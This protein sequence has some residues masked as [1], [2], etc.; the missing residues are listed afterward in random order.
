MK[1]LLNVLFNRKAK[2]DLDNDGKIES[3]RDEVAGVFSQF[4]VMHDK[5]TRVNNQLET[6]VTEESV[7]KHQAEVRITTAMNDMKRNEELQ[8]KLNDFIV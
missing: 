5:L 4:K 6:V 2:V 1:K 3:W 7:K 8:K